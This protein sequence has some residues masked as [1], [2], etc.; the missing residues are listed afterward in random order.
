MDV[1]QGLGSLWLSTWSS[2]YSD[3]D[4]TKDDDF[5]LGIYALFGIAQCKK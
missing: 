1:F 2:S 5:Y 4:L 3:P